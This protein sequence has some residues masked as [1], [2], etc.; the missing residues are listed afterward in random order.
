[1]S[2]FGHERRGHRYMAGMPRPV[3]A[4]PSLLLI[5][6]LAGAC[7]TGSGS[8]HGRPSET[9]DDAPPSPPSVTAP[10]ASVSASALPKVPPIALPPAARVVAKSANICILTREGGEVQCLGEWPLAFITPTSMGSR[11]QYIR[12]LM[13]VSG[14]ANVTSVAVGT[15]RGC[16]VL[17]DG[18]VLCWG[19]TSPTK[20]GWFGAVEGHLDAVKQTEIEGAVEIALDWNENCA[21]LRSGRV[22]CWG[23]R[24]GIIGRKEGPP[25]PPRDLPLTDVVQ[26]VGAKSHFCALTKKGAVKC[27]G[28]NRGGRLGGKPSPITDEAI[29]DIAAPADVVQITA[30]PEHD[31]MLT[32][33]GDVYCWGSNGNGE[34]GD[35][36]SAASTKPVKAAVSD[37]TQVEAADNNSIT[38]ALTRDRKIYCWGDANNCFMGRDVSK[39][40]K[41]EMRSTF[42]FTEAPFCKA[43]MAIPVKIDPVGI[44]VG[45][46][47]ACAWDAAGQFVCWGRSLT[48][49]PGQCEPGSPL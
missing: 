6:I 9:T 3:C 43:P 8:T 12:Q 28:D 2:F 45:T 1:M 10:I 40:D 18:S 39:C 13:G 46:S 25:D 37:V 47:T 11:N 26:I 44:S 34:L 31:C 27:W 4:R 22:R 32:R 29:F 33:G 23:P 17:A 16:G 7:G 19:N 48:G 41:R 42:G 49:K 15:N 35:G 21:R 36:T 14:L 30:G 20:N 38:C 5:A 24:T